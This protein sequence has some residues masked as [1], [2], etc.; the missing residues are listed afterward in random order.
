MQR[1]A[2]Y[3]VT[4]WYEP[5][6]VSNASWVCGYCGNAVASDRGLIDTSGPDN[7]GQGLGYIRLCPHCH[8]PTTFNHS[9][10]YTP[11][12]APGESI[13]NVPSELAKLY[14]EARA[15][16]G[17]GAYTA[18]VLVC[19]KLLMNLAVGEGAEEGKSFFSYVEYLAGNGYIPP[20]GRGWV[21]YIRTR[22]NEAN[23][24]ISFMSFEDASALI[25]FSGMLL[26]FIYELPSLIPPGKTE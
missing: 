2:Q 10:D 20:K 25:G 13:A 11:R 14:D 9:G 16:A 26:R 8:Y 19:R 15:S 17:A 6:I 24:E 3:H 22:G 18:A 12:K 21:D 1:L 7:Y 4:G 5:Q 23:H